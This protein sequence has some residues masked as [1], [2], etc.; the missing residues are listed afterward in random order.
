MYS[1][2][3]VKN[4][5]VFPAYIFCS[6]AGISLAYFSMMST[7]ISDLPTEIN[8]CGSLLFFF[9]IFVGHM[10]IFGATDTPVSDFW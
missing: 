2:L 9:K 1:I 8:N 5:G 7:K 3:H 6:L 10:S 4:T